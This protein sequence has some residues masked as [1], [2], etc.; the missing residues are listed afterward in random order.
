MKSSIFRQLP[1][2]YVG[3]NIVIL[4][5]RKVVCHLKPPSKIVAAAYQRHSEPL[6]ARSMSE[7]IDFSDSYHFV[8]SALAIS[9]GAQGESPRP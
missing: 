5:T 3:L 2:R 6:P 1:L 4:V 9:K 8:M 7:I